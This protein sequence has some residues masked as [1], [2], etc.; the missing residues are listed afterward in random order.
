MPRSRRSAAAKAVWLRPGYR[1]KMCVAQKK[2]WARSGAREKASVAAKIVW[3]SKERRAAA[4]AVWARPGYKEKMRDLMRAARARPEV[5]AKMGHPQ[6]PATRAKISAG[7]KAAWA[8]PEI[9]ARHSAANKAVQSTPEARARASAAMKMIRARPDVRAKHATTRARPEIRAKM[10]AAIKA[11]KAR[12]DA[13][14]C[15]DHDHQSGHVRA[16]LCNFCNRGHYRDDS[17]LLRAAADYRERAPRAEI[18]VALSTREKRLLRVII[19][20][21]QH[22]RC[23]ICGTNDPRRR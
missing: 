17:Q 14:W 9:Y 13:S 22:G 11:A 7:T 16:V 3:G 23:A 20:N 6:S 1:E 15:L 12:P 2:R 18:Y 8:R 19:L 5:R 21:D 4:K 10:G